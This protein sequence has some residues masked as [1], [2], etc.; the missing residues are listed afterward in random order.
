MGR[1]D[2]QP[3]SH[4]SRR[5]QY[6]PLGPRD[7]DAIPTMPRSPQ[8]QNPRNRPS[9]CD[10]HNGL[11]RRSTPR[12]RPSRGHASRYRLRPRA[13]F[14]PAAGTLVSAQARVASARRGTHHRTATPDTRRLGSVPGASRPRGSTSSCAAP[15]LRPDDAG[16][17][18]PDT[19]SLGPRGRVGGRRHLATALS[20]IASRVD[21]ADRV[22]FSETCEPNRT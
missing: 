5:P 6:R 1:S 21:L 22:R 7:R 12:N 20:G 19:G 4:A 14:R 15:A 11:A 17:R 13:P 18:E 9:R 16:R 3:A 2:R 8:H 10:P